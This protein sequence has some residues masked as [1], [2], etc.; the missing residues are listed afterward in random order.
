VKAGHLLY[1]VAFFMVNV[2][3]ALYNFSGKLYFSAETQNVNLKCLQKADIN[4]DIRI[5]K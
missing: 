3:F 5:P 1:E 2:G 4:I